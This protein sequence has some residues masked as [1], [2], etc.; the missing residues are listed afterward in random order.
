MATRTLE[1]PRASHMAPADGVVRA[2]IDQKTKE[3]ASAVLAGLGLTTSDAIRLLLMHVAA[4]GELPFAVG[5]KP[6]AETRAA[7]DELNSGKGRRVKNRK[8]LMADLN[9]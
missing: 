1:R 8:S 3:D 2:R 7:M 9:A 6:N 4:D 5:R